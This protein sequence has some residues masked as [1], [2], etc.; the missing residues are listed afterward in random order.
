MQ[1]TVDEKIYSF[2]S[3]MVKDTFSRKP[4]SFAP[5]SFALKVHQA[6]EI[7]VASA[8]VGQ[9]SGEEIQ[10]SHAKPSKSP[11]KSKF[12]A[13]IIMFFASDA[14]AEALRAAHQF[15]MPQ[16][17]R[18]AIGVM[19]LTSASSADI[20][21]ALLE[22]PGN[23][24]HKWFK[25]VDFVVPVLSPQFL[26]QLQDRDSDPDTLQERQYNRYLYRML[27]DDYV[28]KMSKNYKCRALYVPEYCTEVRSSEL[29]KGNG[30]LQMNWNCSS[31]EEIE[32]LGEILI[33]G[34]RER[35]RRKVQKAS[36]AP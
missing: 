11:K 4:T 29:V 22:D 3:G 9:I 6:P 34:T 2:R 21:N 7:L 25:Q 20:A 14:K 13:R 17:A 31:E 1:V 12:A 27:L 26:R 30:L 28:A 18:K 10:S 23:S 35:Q 16:G 15:R 8:N 32:Q 5:T 24:I 33:S 36:T 19:I